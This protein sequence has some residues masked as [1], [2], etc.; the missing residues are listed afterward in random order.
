M[1]LDITCSCL[2]SIVK[3]TDEEAGD[4]CCGGASF[5]N[6]VLQLLQEEFSCYICDEILVEVYVQFEPTVCRPQDLRRYL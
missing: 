5:K 6:G 2:D 3:G 1:V 4:Y